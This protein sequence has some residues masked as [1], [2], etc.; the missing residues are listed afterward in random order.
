MKK[1]VLLGSFVLTGLFTFSH[2]A[3]AADPICGGSSGEG[4][5]GVLSWGGCILNSY[6]TPLLVT[7]AMVFFIW[8]VI[9]YYLNP[10]NEEKKKK[11]KSFIIGGL[12][13]LFVIIAMWGL[14]GLLVHTFGFDTKP[15]IT[16]PQIPPLSTTGT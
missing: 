12:I 3:V 4:L 15:N 7:I 11:G 8:G 1:I 14:V 10:D 13:A 5:E 2:F 16:V 9:Q 6:V